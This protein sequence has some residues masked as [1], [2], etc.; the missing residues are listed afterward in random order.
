MDKFAVMAQGAPI[1]T[2]LADAGG[3][4][5]LWRLLTPRG[6]M[7]LQ[8]EGIQPWLMDADAIRDILS[9]QVGPWLDSVA[10]HHHEHLHIAFYGAGC[11]NEGPKALLTEL[12]AEALSPLQIGIYS[13]LLAV[14]HAGLGNKQGLVGI[15]GTGCNAAWYDGQKFPLKPISLGFWLGDEG[16]GGWFGKRLI[17]D[18]LRNHLPVYLRED[19]KAVCPEINLQHVLQKMYRESAPSSF[20]GMFT[21]IMAY[22]RGDEYVESLLDEG[23]GLFCKNDLSIFAAC[24]KKDFVF[25]GGVASHFRDALARN[26]EAHGFGLSQVLEDPMDG[27]THYYS[28]LHQN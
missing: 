27:L 11:D 3:T 18:Y 8:T 4:G 20:A 17:V 26:L 9:F 21:R 13:D 1:W 12:L 7:D 15:I 14:A 24:E 25:I 5:T 19:M 23:F 10:G 6:P 16:S 2:L 22:H 28:R